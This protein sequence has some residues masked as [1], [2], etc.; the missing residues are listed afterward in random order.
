MRT[1]VARMCL[2]IVSVPH[3]WTVQGEFNVEVKPLHPGLI[4]DLGTLVNVSLLWS[5]QY[6]TINW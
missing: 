6:L 2:A 3:L 5:L 1:E 4:L